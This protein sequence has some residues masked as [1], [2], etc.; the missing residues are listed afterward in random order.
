[1]LYYLPGYA[2][3]FLNISFNLCDGLFSSSYILYN[4]ASFGTEVGLRD[5]GGVVKVDTIIK[6]AVIKE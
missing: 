5:S 6:N 3:F 1:M 4:L 2:I